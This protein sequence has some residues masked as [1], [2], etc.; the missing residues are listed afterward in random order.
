MIF[1]VLG[2]DCISGCWWG[3]RR[4]PCRSELVRYPC[5]FPA[6]QVIA[7][8]DGVKLGVQKG[9]TIVYQKYAMAEVEIPDGEVLFVAE[10]SILGV[11]S[12]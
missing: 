1:D 7:V 9:D 6:L 11:L 2:G 5:N 3:P 4:N 10:K 8:G 12:Q